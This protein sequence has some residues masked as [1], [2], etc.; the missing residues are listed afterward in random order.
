MLSLLLRSILAD[1]MKS[2]LD[3]RYSGRVGTVLVVCCRTS[4]GEYESSSSSMI[5]RYFWSWPA[6]LARTRASSINLTRVARMECGHS[7]G[8]FALAT[9]RATL[10]SKL[11]GGTTPL[12]G[13]NRCAG[14]ASRVYEMVSLTLLRRDGGLNDAPWRAE[15]SAL[16]SSQTRARP[17]LSCSSYRC[18]FCWRRARGTR[19]RQ[20]A[21]S[22][23]S[24]YEGRIA[25]TTTGDGEGAGAGGRWPTER[26]GTA[27]LPAWRWEGRETRFNLR[28]ESFNLSPAGAF[29]TARGRLH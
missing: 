28:C 5:I 3:W 9:P 24:E 18:S 13:V 2:M 1:F 23:L 4:P 25:T 17:G 22:G 20:G 14:N 7:S 6:S 27:V 29:T 15:G 11:E 8:P 26:A 21:V 10:S 12:K 19:T 16:A